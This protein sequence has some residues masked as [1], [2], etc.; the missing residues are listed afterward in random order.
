MNASTTS[1]MPSGGNG[2]PGVFGQPSAKLNAAAAT[3]KISVQIGG[4][5]LSIMAP[6]AFPLYAIA[7]A[8]LVA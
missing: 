8:Q 7:L 2:K 6:C 1:A 3:R 4:G 5:K